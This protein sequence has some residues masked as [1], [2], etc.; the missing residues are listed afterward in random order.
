MRT[1][2]APSDGG[3][4]DVPS[5]APTTASSTSSLSP[6]PTNTHSSDSSSAGRPFLD[7]AQNRTS[8]CVSPAL[9]NDI[10]RTMSR[11]LDNQ[12]GTRTSAENASS[13]EESSEETESH[14]HHFQSDSEDDKMMLERV[15]IGKRRKRRILFSKSQTF[16]LERRFRQQ[17][18]LS[19]PEREELASRLRLT[20]TQVKIWFQNHRYKTKKATHDKTS[21]AAIGG[22][23]MASRRMPIPLL[24]HDPR[25]C[26]GMQ[27]SAE[28]HNCVSNPVSMVPSAHF[29]GLPVDAA[30]P[31]AVGLFNGVGPFVTAAQ[32]GVHQHHQAQQVVGSMIRPSY[33]LQNAW[34]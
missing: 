29:S 31:G 15:A 4:L 26:G 13:V 24:L 16:E 33:Y 10:L 21:S 27:R 12:K 30:P 34:W 18:Y 6:A 22:S 32:A 3:H 17:K 2:A 28:S 25:P 14:H 5:A 19:A 23:L 7:C 9:A 20:P 11:K 8:G 1:E